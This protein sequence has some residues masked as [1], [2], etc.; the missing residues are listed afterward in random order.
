MMNR[1]WTELLCCMA[2]MIPPMGPVRISQGAAGKQ[3]QKQAKD[4]TKTSS[5]ISKTLRAD[6]AEQDNPLSGI[7]SKKEQ[8]LIENTDFSLS[9]V[10]EELLENANVNSEEVKDID[11]V[12]NLDLHSF[13]TVNKDQSKTLHMF[14]SP[15]KYYDK[16][17]NEIKFIDND[18]MQ[19]NE[20]I[21]GND[22]YA[23]ENKDNAIKVYLPENSRE[24]VTI[25]NQEESSL[26]F[27]PMG[28]KE[29]PV[30][31]KTVKFLG[32]EEK[33]AE[34]GDAF[35]QGYDLQYIPQSESVKENILFNKH[36]DI[37]C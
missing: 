18:F 21:S 2:L 16:E 29:V 36:D 13:T 9:D 8:E 17:E 19:S 28:E 23:Y 11:G 15:V 12:D 5:K 22:S 25:M 33:V 30:R 37:V 6:G 3:S 32:E 26:S 24:Y 20:I 4:V 34:Y 27:S 10:P 31:K 35:G 14:E 1:K 7:P